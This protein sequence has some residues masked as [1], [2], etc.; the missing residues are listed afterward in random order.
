[1]YKPFKCTQ[2]VRIHWEGGAPWGAIDG[3][4]VG[5]AGRVL[6]TTS[7]VSKLLNECRNERLENSGTSAARCDEVWRVKRRSDL[8]D[9]DATSAPRLGARPTRLHDR[10][11]VEIV[12]RL[13]ADH[14]RGSL[15]EQQ[16]AEIVARLNTDHDSEVSTANDRRSSGQVNAVRAGL[17]TLSE[18]P[19]RRAYIA[20]RCFCKVRAETRLAYASRFAARTV[21]AL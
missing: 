12:D 4:Q 6:L 16:L 14:G 2:S 15:H 17:Q 3:R 5:W 1:M 21:P 19:A 11:L 9:A 18:E 7:L 13:N 10:Q 8:T 20:V